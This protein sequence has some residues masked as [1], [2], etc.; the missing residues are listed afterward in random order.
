[1]KKFLLNDVTLKEIVKAS[2]ISLGF[3]EKVEIVKLLNKINVDVIELPQIKNKAADTLFVKTVSKL[4]DNSVITLPVEL[5]LDGINDAVD[6]LKDAKNARIQVCVPT[7]I[8]QME[9]LCHKKPKALLEMIGELI[10]ASKEKGICVEFVAL[11]A[12]RGEKEF[13]F[14]AIEKATNNGAD[15]VT[16]SDNAGYMLPNDFA[17][18]ISEISKAIPE[19]VSLGVECNNAIEMAV[20]SSIASV[21]SGAVE[22][23]TSTVNAEVTSLNA[24]LQV[25]RIKGTEL[26]MACS[27]D[28][29]KSQRSIEQISRII[30]NKINSKTKVVLSSAETQDF[31]LN[32]FDDLSEVVK[33]IEKLGYD[34]SEEDCNKVYNEFKNIAEKKNI[35]AKELEA[36]IASEALQVPNTYALESYV[37]NSGNIINST[38]NL[39]V[40]KDGKT[41][42]G[43]GIGDGPIDAAFV[44]IEQIV[45]HHYELDDFQIQSVTEGREAMGHALIKLRN[46]G[47]LYAGTGISTD[48]IGASIRAYLNALNKIVY[49]EN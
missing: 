42:R 45:G 22:I 19:N 43:V 34:L 30:N 16:I 28:L 26:D 6:A 38:A 48:I 12:T 21:M 31:V 15:I 4:V 5:S 7:S 9:Y 13:L 2:D 8:V 29:T 44:A 1:M 23:K 17:A 36:I 32:S 46:N 49:E 11:D 10:T 41:L 39:E 18:F 33:A 14:A 47:K 40:T 25:L 24:I 20:A 35:T 27:I 37:I 3:R